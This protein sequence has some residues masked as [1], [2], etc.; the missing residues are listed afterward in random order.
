MFPKLYKIQ[1]DCDWGEKKYFDNKSF[2]KQ[3]IKLFT[4]NL[5]CFLFTWIIVF[6]IGVHVL[7]R[8]I[9]DFLKPQLIDSNLR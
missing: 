1:K 6:Q 2:T 7:W 5:V 8:N 3:K 4:K 9:Q